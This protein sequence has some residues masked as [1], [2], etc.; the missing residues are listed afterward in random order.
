M[1]W[2]E[3][4]KNGRKSQNSGEK[5]VQPQSGS[6]ARSRRPKAVGRKILR[7]ASS[8]GGPPR[9]SVRVQ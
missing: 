5:T 4:P 9:G 1:G 6:P 3:W 7:P 2:P 8:G